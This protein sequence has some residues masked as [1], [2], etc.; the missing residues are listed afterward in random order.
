[1][2]CRIWYYSLT[3]FF[4]DPYE[5][6]GNFDVH[7][8]HIQSSEYEYRQFITVIYIGVTYKIDLPNPNLGLFLDC[9]DVLVENATEYNTLQ[10]FQILIPHINP[11]YR[12]QKHWVIS[13][14]WETV[15]NYYSQYFIEIQ[16]FLNLLAV[17]NTYTLDK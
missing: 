15:F 16:E 7:P 17:E 11:Q 8:T 3:K 4:Q 14:N 10:N 12:M 2:L 6:T 5:R 1:M 13:D 9:I